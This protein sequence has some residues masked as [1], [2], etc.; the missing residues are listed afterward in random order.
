MIELDIPPKSKMNIK[1]EYLGSL[2]D[3][4]N[5]KCKTSIRDH[6]TCASLL[7]QMSSV[8]NVTLQETHTPCER[9]QQCLPVRFCSGDGGHAQKGALHV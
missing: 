9:P 1:F 8:T 4:E 6:Q 3:Q 2:Q 5:K 7:Q